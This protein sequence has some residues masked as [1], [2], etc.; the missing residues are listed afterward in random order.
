M[1]TAADAVVDQRL[2][3]LEA[4]NRTLRAQFEQFKM[5]AYI[6]ALEAGKDWKDLCKRAESRM[7]ARQRVKLQR[8]EG[9]SPAD[10]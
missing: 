2:G 6:M 4:E 9:K 10:G 7:K 1:P 3:A 8:E 5:I